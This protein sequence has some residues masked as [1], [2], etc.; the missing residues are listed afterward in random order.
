[1]ELQIGPIKMIE[2]TNGCKVPFSRSL[3]IKGKENILIETGSDPQNLISLE[4]EFGVDYVINTHYHF[5]HTAQNYL[6]KRAE[7][8]INPIEY[9]STSTIEDVAKINGIYE[10]WGDDGVEKW[11]NTVPE[12]WIDSL[13]S[14]TGKYEYNKE[15]KFSNV[16]IIFLH[17]PGHTAGLA[18]PYF[19]HYGVVY[20]SDYDMTSFGPWYNGSDGDIEQF[21]QSGKKLLELDAHT[22]ITGH[23]K[24]VFSK[25]EFQLAMEQFLSII[26][27]RDEIITKLIHQGMGLKE[28]CNYGIFYPKQ[29]LHSFSFQTWERIGI[30]K[31]LQRL[32]LEVN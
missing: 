10:V 13:K 6:F 4:K 9:E 28:I 27:K 26:D 14:F 24:G 23:Q 30:R 8:W 22:Y 11:K 5:D 15:Y 31:H 1:M 2:A 12:T 20:V 17:T 25:K 32:Q 7:K 18:S 21:I 3:F 29:F 16:T 19:P